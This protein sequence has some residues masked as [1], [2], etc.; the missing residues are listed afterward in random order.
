MSTTSEYVPLGRGSDLWTKDDTNYVYIEDE[1]FFPVDSREGKLFLKG[2][3]TNKTKIG[4]SLNEE[5]VPII[6][7]HKAFCKTH[8]WL[9]QDNISHATKCDKYLLLY[10][11]DI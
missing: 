2:R 10:R 11:R 5:V 4:A 8:R 6:K 7:D 3:K 1:G 9:C